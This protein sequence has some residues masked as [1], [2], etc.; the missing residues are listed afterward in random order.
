[1]RKVIVFAT[2]AVA[3]VACA[4]NE[5][6]P[7]GTSTKDEIT[8]NVA[9]KTKAVTVSDFN[10]KLKFKSY[11]YYLESAGATPE[12]YI[13]DE[14]IYYQKPEGAKDSVW[15]ADNSYYWP[16][17]EGSSLTFYAWTSL[18][19]SN[20]G[21]TAV[22]YTYDAITGN[23]GTVSCSAAGGIEVKDFDI[24]KNKNIDVLV[25]DSSAVQTKNKHKYNHNGVPTL[26]KHKLSYVVFTVKTDKSYRVLDGNLSDPGDKIFTLQSITFKGL[27]YKGTYNQF[28]DEKWTISEETGTPDQVYFNQTTVGKTISD[29]QDALTSDLTLNYYLPQEFTADQYFEIVY[30]IKTQVTTTSSVTET[31]T[32]KVY[33]NPASSEAV[34]PFADAKWEI[35]KKYTVNLTFSLD[36]ITWDPAVEDWTPADASDITVK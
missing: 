7:V 14:E 6:L 24:T 28:T 20:A 2:T 11:A 29:T 26:F 13:N 5:V 4:K 25:A 36:E 31:V 35:G 18:K 16:K 10:H 17:K 15:R 23:R 1:M 32:R 21:T 27:Q 33:L 8:F 9:P 34:K 12:L 30:T 3:L 19:E 22:K